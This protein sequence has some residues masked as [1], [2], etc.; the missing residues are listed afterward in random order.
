VLR[1]CSRF[2]RR[3]ASARSPSVISSSRISFAATEDPSAERFPLD[4]LRDRP[5]VRLAE[6]CF[7]VFVEERGGGCPDDCGC[8]IMEER[9]EDP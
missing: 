8:L 5:S 7:L 4:W 6:D 2:R 3:L 1:A 9:G